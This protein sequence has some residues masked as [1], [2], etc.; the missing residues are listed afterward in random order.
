M[1]LLIIVLV[2]GLYE[3]LI[4]TL[5][6]TLIVVLKALI[7]SF[8]FFYHLYSL[9]VTLAPSAMRHIINIKKKINIYTPSETSLSKFKNFKIKYKLPLFYFV[10]IK[11]VTRIV[12]E[13]F[14]F[15]FGVNVLELFDSM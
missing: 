14:F 15:F 2:K 5:K 12:L 7:L 11:V 3:I 1:Y 6:K 10:I 4:M 13:L 9:F 8:F